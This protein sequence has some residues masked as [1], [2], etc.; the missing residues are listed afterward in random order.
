MT[1]CGL[2][3]TVAH[4]PKRQREGGITLFRSREAMAAHSL[5]RQPKDSKKDRPSAA[6]RRQQ[7]LPQQ[8]AG[9][10]SRLLPSFLRVRWAYAQGYVLSPLRGYEYT[11]SRLAFLIADS[12]HDDLAL[13][14]RF[15]AE[16]GNLPTLVG[17]V[18]DTHFRTLGQVLTLPETAEVP[19][20]S[21]PQAS[22]GT[23]SNRK[24]RTRATAS[25]SET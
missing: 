18:D 20:G 16:H 4:S 6:K 17:L 8:P 19:I 1:H 25:K 2:D 12:R 24:S 7:V 22:T 21:Q 23:K 13:A 15:F 5:G 9:A 14:L 3:R 11:T 10:A